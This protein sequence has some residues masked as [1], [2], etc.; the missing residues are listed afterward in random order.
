[1][2]SQGVRSGGRG[3]ESVTVRASKAMSYL[4]RHGA[5]KEGLPIRSDG[6]VPVS[7]VLAHKTLV[8]LKVGP[9]QLEDIVNNNDKKRYELKDIDGVPHIKAVQGHSMADVH[10]LELLPV[11]LEDLPNFPTVVHGTYFNCWSSI[12]KQGLSK[13]GRLHIHFA[14]GELGDKEVISGMRRSAQVLVFL[15]LETALKDTIPFFKSPNNVILS[16]G[17]KEGIIEP[18]YFKQ[19]VDAQT[20][21]PLRQPDGTPSSSSSSSLSVLAPST[22]SAPSAP[23]TWASE[24]GAP[25]PSTAKTPTP[26]SS[27]STSSSASS[28]SSSSFDYLC[29]LDFEATCENNKRIT[30]EVIEFPGVLVDVKAKKVISQIQLYCRPVVNSKLTPFCTEL[31]GIT[32][33]T[34]DGGVSFREAW[35]DYNQWLNVNVPG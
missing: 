10:E 19:V 23:S 25:S 27:S 30:Q 7:N 17:N 14:I 28:S 35:K 29:V 4:L 8:S 33:Q 22:S 16:P 11:T 12:A 31:T 3:G 1:M 2:A 5:L 32:Q 20:R 15:D 34:V 26:F 24:L 6:F 18:K 21:R 13:M 9:R